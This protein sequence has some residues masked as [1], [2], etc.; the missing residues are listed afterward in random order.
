MA[1]DMGK[2]HITRQMPMNII[3][4]LQAINIHQGER[5]WPVLA[6]RQLEGAMQFALDPPPIGKARQAIG[7]GQ[8]LEPDD[9]GP[10]IVNFGQKGRHRLV[11]R[12][13]R[14]N[15][16]HRSSNPPAGLWVPCRWM[17]LRSARQ[18]AKA[19]QPWNQR[20]TGPSS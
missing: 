1:R 4:R 20:R 6:R 14:E 8:M 3:N 19:C 5:R 13:R 11:G 18:M 9:F 7:I 16:V 12:A 2:H 17:T 15:G 10:Q